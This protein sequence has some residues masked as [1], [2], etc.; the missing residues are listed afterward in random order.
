MRQNKFSYNVAEIYTLY[1]I[2]GVA[3]KSRIEQL[4]TMSLAYTYRYLLS[5]TISSITTAIKHMNL[6]GHKSQLQ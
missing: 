4:Q 1:S 3:N 2:D 5:V 6:S